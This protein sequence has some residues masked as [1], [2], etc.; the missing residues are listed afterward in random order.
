MPLNWDVTKVKYFAEN[1]DDL[2][3][4]YNKGT[5]DEYQD[6]SAET[7]SFIFGTM[8]IGIGNIKM[9]NAS[10]FYAR[11]RLMEKFDGHYVY[12]LLKDGEI[13]RVYICPE[14][15]MK[16][17]GLSTNVGN[18]SKKEWILR[19]T[20]SWANRSDIPNMK[21]KDIEKKYNFYKAEFE[22]HFTA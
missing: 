3:T 6:V 8:M 18:V 12:S 5:A 13:E 11:W 22:S 17:I 14:M 21:V 2:W 15:V 4:T 7:K 9:S 19:L 20:K 16:H 1:P 10:D